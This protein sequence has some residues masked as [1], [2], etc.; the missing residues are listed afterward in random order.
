[1]GLVG[2][3]AKRR[4]VRAV[5]AVLAVIGALACS[6]SDDDGTDRGDPGGGARPGEPE[7]RGDPPDD[8]EVARDE[9]EPATGV[10]ITF[11]P[12]EGADAYLVVLDGRDEPVRVEAESCSGMSC[13]VVLD[14]LTTADADRLTVTTVSGDARSRPSGEVDVPAP[15][16]PPRSG[17]GPDEPVELV[18]TRRGPGGVPEVTT[19]P[20]PA[21]TDVE[22]RVAA[23]AAEGD[24]LGV[25]IDEPGWATGRTQGADEES[26]PDGLATWQQEA[27][28]FDALPPG[29]RGDGVTVAVIDSGIDPDHPALDGLDVTGTNVVTGGAPTV[30]D[31]GTAVTSLIAGQPGGRVPGVA[32]GVTVLAY[33]VFDGAAEFDRSDL[34]RAIVQAVDDGADVINLSLSTSCNQIGPYHFDCPPGGLEPAIDYAESEGVVVVASAGNNGDG[35]DYCDGGDNTITGLESNGDL[36]P[37]S[38]ET[39]IAVGGSDRNGEQWVCSPDKDYIDVLAPADALLVASVTDADSYVVGSGTSFA[40]PLVTGLIATILAEQPD[41]T[42]AEVRTLLAAATAEHGR[43]LPGVVL[44]RLGL[45]TGRLFDP[46]TL[47]RIMPFRATLSYPDDHPVGE[48]ARSL[49]RDPA[50]PDWII[51]IYEFF[52]EGGGFEIE[53]GGVLL[54][55]ED[56]TVGGQGRLTLSDNTRTEYGPVLARHQITCPAGGGK[57]KLVYGWDIPV[58]FGGRFRDTPGSGLDE[59]DMSL[60]FGEGATPDTAGDLPGITIIEDTLAGCP[61][62]IPGDIEADGPQQQRYEE[63]LARRDSNIPELEGLYSELLASSPLEV[64]AAWPQT[65]EGEA[66]LNTQSGDEH[67]GIAVHFA[68]GNDPQF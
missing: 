54:V 34:A 48:L 32:P 14:R 59:V 38:Y 29:D 37:A 25:G 21:G 44:G 6:G 8:V 67:D 65:R 9:G 30:G 47:S 18:V 5:V 56:G 66:L 39:V 52:P 17:A 45:T 22:A 27:F 41:L 7:L 63:A 35:A 11:A 42:P 55:A 49:Y 23:L 61:A 4:A 16:D 46:T 33:D 43:L 31:H 19:E 53:A 40:A 57:L 68:L 64:T 51:E 13:R 26:Y 50:S 62:E 20:A 58:T 1:V 60:S 24:V 15:P 12:V 2:D 3:E 36:W 10:E 28:D